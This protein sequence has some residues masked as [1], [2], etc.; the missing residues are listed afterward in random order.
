MLLEFGK[1]GWIDKARQQPELKTDGLAVTL[2]AVK[3]KLDHPL[4]LGYCNEGKVMRP[5]H[6]PFLFHSCLGDRLLI[7]P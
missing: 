3:N 1:A 4:A 5:L 7:V 2:A 6:N